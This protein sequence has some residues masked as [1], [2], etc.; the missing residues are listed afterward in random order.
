M[1]N[2]I[3][4][5]KFADNNEKILCF[6]CS[7]IIL[8]PSIYESGGMSAAEG[9]AY[10][11]PAIG[12]DLP[13]YDTYYPKG[14]LKVKNKAEFVHTILKLLKDRLLWNK[15]SNDAFDLVNTEWNWD[16]RAEAIYKEIT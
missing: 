6:Y 9:M 5:K 13:V 16:K 4:F 3:L 12:F 11:I 8:H 14:M 15:I 7:K 2:N 10:R 1:L